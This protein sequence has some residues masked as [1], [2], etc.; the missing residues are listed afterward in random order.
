MKHIPGPDFPTAAFIHGTDGI[1][2]AYETG[3]GS[4]Q[5]RARANIE[6]RKRG[7]DK[8]SIVIS[9]IPYQ[10]NKARLLERIA[11]LVRDK[12]V[13]GVSD[14]RDESDRDGI[15]IVVELKRGEVP[16]VI[17]N[18][19]Y[20]HTPLQTSFGIILLA[21]VDNQPKVLN[22]KD[23]LVHFLNHRKTVVIRRTRF[24]L[25]KAEERA[26]ILEGILKALD[27]LDEIIATI[28]SSHT[29]KEAK[30]RLMEDFSLS[31]PQAQAILDMRLQKLTGLE[32]EKIVEEYEALLA[33]IERL[34]AI[35]GSDKLLLDEIRRELKE[36]VEAYGDERRTEIIPETKDI[37][38][39]DM[40]ADEDMVITVSSTGYVKRSPLS[41]YRA[42]HRGGKGRTGM[43]PKDGDFVEHLHVAS[44]HS[45]V[46]VFT[47]AGQVHCCLLYTSPSP[48]DA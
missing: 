3:R 40:I 39:E 4:I 19:L 33:L 15:R 30:T 25:R 21:I 14:L 46:L 37:S 47:E 36:V 48:R 17:L 13:T 6:T 44:A 34:R 35:L 22:L 45:Y 43:A 10:V 7:G 42:Q 9:E 29:P 20:K 28:R 38:I 31:D 26:H 27:Q 12:K 18:T 16:E 8:Q 1:K 32:R 41:I 24:D 23:I 5:M 11:D 2:S